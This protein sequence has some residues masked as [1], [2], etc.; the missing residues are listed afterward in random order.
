MKTRHVFPIAIILGLTILMAACNLPASR[1]SGSTAP[2][3]TIE[4]PFIAIY[5]NSQ[6]LRDVQAGTL[7]AAAVLG[8][9]A[10][11]PTVTSTLGVAHDVIPTVGMT[12]LVNTTPQTQTTPTI[13]G[14]PW[15]TPTPGYPATY[16]L[17]EGE[18]CYCIARRFNVNPD[19]LISANSVCS[20]NYQTPGTV[21][22][23]PQSGSF[24]AAR[25]RVTHPATYT[26]RAGDT[27]YSIA[28]GYGDVD[29]N[30][31]IAA[32]GLTS[33]YTLTSGTTLNIP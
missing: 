15:P 16:T 8:T 17:Q 25:A 6:T 22:T 10:V 19:D 23:I 28:C 1:S 12:S 7:T 2:T 24:P 9:V 14:T 31:I 27:I 11:T 5:T 33:P 20:A 21:L 26:V 18:Y 4:T 30:I 13:T 3:A 32:N 29:P